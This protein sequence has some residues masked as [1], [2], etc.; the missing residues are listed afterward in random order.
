MKLIYFLAIIL[1]EL[2]S[3]CTL[4]PIRETHFSLRKTGAL[5][6]PPE[7]MPADYTRGA[8]YPTLVKMDSIAGFPYEYALYFSTDHTKGK[9]GIWLYLCQ[10]S[11]NDASN[12]ISYEAAIALGKFN[13]LGYKPLSNPIYVD[14]IA[15]R[16]TETPHANIINGKVYMS[17]HNNMDGMQATLMATS[18]DGVNFKRLYNDNQA[19]ILKPKK[20]LHH[21]GYFRWG[22]N[23]FTGVNYK[24]VGYSLYGG[25]FN[26]R[27]A[28]WGSDDA[29]QWDEIALFASER[30]DRSLEEEGLLLI[31]H[32]LDPTS[33]R[34]ITNDEYVAVM[35][36]G[37]LAAGQME[38]VNELY[39]VYL[40]KD[41]Y[42]LKRISHK[43]LQR[44]PLDSDDSEE[45]NTSSMVF[46]GDTL[47]MI[48]LGTKNRGQIN[49]VMG[50]IGTF[51]P[52]ALLTPE[53]KFEDQKAHIFSQEEF[54]QEYLEFQEKSS[55]KLN[56]VEKN[57]E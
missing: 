36:A 34:K 40:D 23:P 19:I 11:P 48:Y 3:S 56:R 22:A 46:I 42:T 54:E 12:W 45:L 24:Y 30:N 39:E 32:D 38:R 2:F 44:G 50:A 26:Y 8:Y 16:Q 21:T 55:E 52:N 43:I 4:K 47:H 15:G 35:S 49:T 37:S 25:G 28:M 33:I 1:I 27:S 17:Y 41:G 31:W 10:G 57:N 51:C 7:N 14:T 20:H 6:T 53:L 5:I 29:I 9:G 13:Y 18:D